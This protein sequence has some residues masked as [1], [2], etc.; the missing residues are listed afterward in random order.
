VTRKKFA[1]QLQALK[2]GGFHTIS[3]AQYAHYAATG[4]TSQLPQNPILLTFDDGRLDSYQ[5]ADASLERFHDQATMF[6]VAAWPEERPDWALHWS[7][8]AKMQ[9]SGRWDIQ[10]HAGSGHHHI[11][12]GPHRKQG[13][14]YADLRWEHGALESFDSYEKRVVTDIKWGE[15]MFREHIPDWEP[16]AFAV[17]YSNYGQRATNDPRIPE[18]FFHFIHS[19]FPVLVDGDYLDFGPDRPS[20]IKGRGGHRISYRITQGGASDTLPL[21]EC[22]LR[23]F[24]LEVPLWREYSC[25]KSSGGQ[26]PSEFSE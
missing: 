2:L 18:F 20:E 9:E 21:L 24:V 1:E 14:Y 8:L 15:Q 23:D 16:L 19:Q 4:D 26:V 25:L 5:G 17:P 12:I 13:E 6:V 22:R 10:E 11:V 3:I 7:E